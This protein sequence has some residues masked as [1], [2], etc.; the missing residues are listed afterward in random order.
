[1]NDPG[2]LLSLKTPLRAARCGP[3]EEVG[4]RVLG[5]SS[6]SSSAAPLGQFAQ[7]G[8][9]YVQNNLATWRF[10][11]ANAWREPRQRQWSRAGTAPPP[12][13]PQLS[14]FRMGGGRRTLL[15]Y[16]VSCL[17][18][19]PRYFWKGWAPGWAV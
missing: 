18:T 5:L 3:A 12:E 14:S 2:L 4:G 11:W 17:A 15:L 10:S 19:A 7:R 9:F 8:G 16:R 13:R 1:M 6:N